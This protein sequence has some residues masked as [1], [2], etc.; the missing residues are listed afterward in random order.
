VQLVLHLVPQGGSGQGLLDEVVEAPLPPVEPGTEG[1]VVVDRLR[2]GVR[3]LE[4]H[5]DPPADLGGVDA[6]AV[7][8]VALVADRSFDPGAGYEVVHPVEAAED[9]ALA[10]A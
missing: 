7:D 2:E 8:V 6:L 4:H 3:L 1:D 9:G 10:A 5:A